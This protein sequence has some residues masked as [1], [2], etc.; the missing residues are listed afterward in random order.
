VKLVQAG[1]IRHIGL[2]ECSPETLRKAC[3]VHPIAAVQMEYS[4]WFRGAE[5]SMLPTCRELGVGFV[6]YS[7]LGRRRSRWPGCSRRAKTSC[8]FRARSAAN[9]RRRM[10]RR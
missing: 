7:P 1:K 8:R 9:G 3:K 5:A 2:S 10:R 6:A 4:V